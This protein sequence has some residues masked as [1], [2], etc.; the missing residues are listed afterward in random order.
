M[1]QFIPLD[2]SD[3]FQDFI[4]DLF[5]STY[6]DQSF[7]TFGRNGH[8][9]KGIDII[10]TKNQIVIQ[11]KKKD[12]ILRKERD[13][14]NELK[15]EIEKEPLK[16]VN[17]KLQISFQTFIIASTYKNNPEL[18]EYCSIIKKKHNF[19]FDLQ[20]Y[21]WDTISKKLTSKSQLIKKYYGNFDLTEHYNLI[22]HSIKRNLELKRRFETDFKDGIHLQR[23]IIKKSLD[24]D[25]PYANENKSN[26]ISSWFRVNLWNYYYNGIEIIVS[27]N[28]RIIKDE[29]G[30][31][32]I[33]D[34][35]DK[36][37]EIF[38]EVRSIL[39]IGQIPYSN[40]VDFDFKGDDIYN[41]PHIYCHFSN[42]DEP[43]ENFEY[44]EKFEDESSKKPTYWPLD[45][46]KRTKLS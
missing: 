35:E 33:L 45:K 2:N 3:I 32:D 25:Y 39:W 43:Y 31:W 20:Y 21:G 38:T 24:N 6:N 13:I 42:N 14:I 22:E 46:S 34:F 1:Y 4:C 10:S 23:V 11:C 26:E 41:E 19:N 15:K 28:C 7:M 9:Q 8:K 37:I 12:I 5:N 36:R 27:P 18:Q 44:L 17:E 16:A 29:D 40:I 30:F